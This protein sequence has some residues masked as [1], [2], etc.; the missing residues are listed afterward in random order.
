MGKFMKGCALTALV[1]IGAGIIMAVVGGAA[2]GTTT[3]HEVVDKV[4]GGLV[5]VNL[6]EDNE[7]GVTIGEK[8]VGAD[9]NT[10]IHY[11]IDESSIF[12]MD[13]EIF[14]G[15]YQDTF[16]ADGIRRLDIETGGCEFTVKESADES[17]H[18][19][20]EE[21]NK[22]QCYRKDE[23]LHIKGT[24]KTAISN[25]V[26]PCKITLYVPKEAA[27]E[28]LLLE[29]G[30]GVVDLGTLRAEKIDLEVGAGQI[31]ADSLTGTDVMISV[32]VGECIVKDMQ[33]A[34][35]DAEV[36]MGNLNVQGA[37]S[38]KIILECAMGNIEMQVDGAFSDYDY[39]VECGLGNVLIGDKSYSGASE[40]SV[41][42]GA[43][44]K[45]DVECAVGNIE[46]AFME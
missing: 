35:L 27:F 17:F 18:V 8:L 22:F 46:I 10:G 9:F 30:A 12:D 21:T 28:K 29:V 26:K 2:K 1:L 25:N 6:G 5:Q 43:S 36:N 15:D 40:A 3:I 13:F 42:N 34:K 37:V 11:D 45:M 19:E 38:E 31:L 41:N 4:T 24:M 33:A 20:A 14:S 39:D 32:G 16:A 7:W 44:R 23:T